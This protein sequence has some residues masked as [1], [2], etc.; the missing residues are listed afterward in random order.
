MNSIQETT[1]DETHASVMGRK[2]S[3][4]EISFEDHADHERM[5]RMIRAEGDVFRLLALAPRGEFAVP[6]RKWYYMIQTPFATFPKFVIGLT[7]DRNENPAVIFR[8]ELRSSAEDFWKKHCSDHQYA[9][10]HPAPD[11]R[12]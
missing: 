5:A 6:G 11:T 9:Y 7:D 8:C 10:S 2:M 3:R 12:P 4:G 1:T